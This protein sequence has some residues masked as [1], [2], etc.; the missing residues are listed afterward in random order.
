MMQEYKIQVG[1]RYLSRSEVMVLTPIKL[2][3]G[4]RIFIKK[5]GPEV[6][7]QGHRRRQRNITDEDGQS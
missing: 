5:K 2:H 4:I 6:V 1:Y 3:R 7:W